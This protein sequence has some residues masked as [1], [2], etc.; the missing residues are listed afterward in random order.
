M[1]IIVHKET[2]RNTELNDRIAADLRARAQTSELEDPDLVEDTDYTKDMKK[3][4]R[5]GWIWAVLVALALISL[6]FIVLI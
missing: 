4:G 3:T 1:G 6:A 2:E 5:F